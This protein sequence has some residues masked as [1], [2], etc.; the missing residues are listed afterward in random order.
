MAV[1]R[2]GLQGPGWAA[3]AW[4]A[5]GRAAMAWALATVVEMKREQR[6]QTDLLEVIAHLQGWKG[7]VSRG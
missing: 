6:V 4:E 5:E 1:A 3:P 2:G 7:K